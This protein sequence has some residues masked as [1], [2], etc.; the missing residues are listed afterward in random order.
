MRAKLAMSGLLLLLTF[1]PWTAYG[2]MYPHYD[3][4]ASYSYDGT[5]VHTSVV[6]DGYASGCCIPPSVTH[7]PVSYNWTG[8]VG[9]WDYG[10]PKCWTCYISTENDQTVAASEGDEVEF[11]SEGVVICSEV[12]TFYDSAETTQFLKIV[13]GSFKFNSLSGSTCNY[14]PTCT[15]TCT[16]SGR[17]SATTEWPGGVCPA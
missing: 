5:N 13:V 1:L 15:G 8:S 14:F 10:T 16:E 7:Q 17:I 9:S 11:D 4:Y 2:Q 12:G 3:V 6:T